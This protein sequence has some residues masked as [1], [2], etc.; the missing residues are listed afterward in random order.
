[1]LTCCDCVPASL[2]RNLTWASWPGWYRGAAGSGTSPKG[3]GPERQPVP[4]RHFDPVPTV[5]HPS[6][7]T[8]PA[9]VI[10]LVILKKIEAYRTA[11]GST[12]PVYRE[13]GSELLALNKSFR[14]VTLITNFPAA[15]ALAQVSK[16]LG[17][18]L[19]RADAEPVGR[20]LARSE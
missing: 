6:P 2:R 12:I 4:V 19:G 17:G 10:L 8:V 5:L 18:C 9:L 7:G 3:A 1:M 15:R 14:T 20:G 16:H 13:L 11:F